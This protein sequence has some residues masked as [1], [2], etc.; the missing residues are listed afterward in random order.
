VLLFAVKGKGEHSILSS[1]KR[2]YKMLDF[3]L[4]MVRVNGL[5]MGPEF[6]NG[7]QIYC[8]HLQAKDFKKA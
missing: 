3:A 1:F 8:V 7:N 4:A 6:T 5:P 2:K